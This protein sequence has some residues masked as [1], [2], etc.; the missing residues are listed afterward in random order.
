MEKADA[1]KLADP[2]WCARVCS[3]FDEQ[4]ASPAG[5]TLPF[6]R[7][8]I[9]PTAALSKTVPLAALLLQTSR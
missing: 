5:K 9:P 3:W 6:H 4:F 2:E 8:F 1:E 7:A